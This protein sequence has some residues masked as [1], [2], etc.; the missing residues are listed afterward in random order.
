M[1]KEKKQFM[2]DLIEEIQLSIEENIKRE[3]PDII[4][5][6][7]S[8][9]WL[10]L[11]QR[12]NNPIDL[13]PMQKVMLK[14]FY[15][16]SLGNE[17][18]KLT[19]IE[20]ELL[21]ENN[22]D[23]DDRGNVLEK[24]YSGDLFRELVLVWGRRSGKDFSVAIIALYEA[25]KLLECEGGDPYAMYGLSS[26][27]PIN[28]LTVANAKG[29]ANIAFSEI[30]EK[31]LYS[32]Y[33][34]DKYIKEGIS[35]GSIYLL[36]PQDKIDNKKFKEQGL[37]QK[38]GSVGIL[39]GHSNSD[40]LLGM[41]CIVLILDEVAS[42]KTTGGSS[43]GDRIYAALTPTVQT[44]VRKV[45]QKDKNGEIELDQHG[46]KK[47][48]ER[49]YDGKIIS[50]SSPRAKEGKF[51]E[52]FNTA[53]NVKN[54]L[55]MRVPTWGI[56]IY[57]TRKSLRDDNNTMSEADF[58]MEFG[59]DFSGTGFE[60]FF[61]EEQIK[62]CFIGHNLKNVEMGSPGKIYFVHLDPA[63]SSHNYS[64]V[65]LHKEYYL[66]QQTQKADFRI[67]VDHIKFWQPINGS[68][69][70]NEV[71][72]YVLSLKRKFRIGLVTY[73][74]FASQESILKMRKAGIPNKETKFTATY[75]YNIYKELENLI[76]TGRLFI[77][78]GDDA[79]HLLYNEMIE[80]QRKFTPTGFKVLPKKEGDGAKSDDIVDSL[81]GACYVAIEKQMS[82]LPHSK[83][84]NL[85][86]PGGQQIAW[87]NMQGG[88]Y[89][90]GTGHQVANSLARRS[91]AYSNLN[92]FGRR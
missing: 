26:A 86:N 47:I 22:L 81:A 45:Y 27:A 82:K 59:A 8:E 72:Q 9:E 63:T 54:R 85:G 77:P 55:A 76:N 25:M 83:L 33:F 71:M 51:Y 28:I 73:D 10:G 60:S 38:K 16:G 68:I 65:D 12:E 2:G 80:L 46:Q 78:F 50:I 30:R 13:F 74:S 18:L 15:R 69:N 66:N 88:V 39:V 67:V 20:L 3:I 58:N 43:S 64:L 70:P 36:T 92:R 89:G 19:D 37:P 1:A 14:T 49:I 87:R 32:P 21:K 29:Q 7:E 41:G 35:A 5:F 48:K 52:L 56:N 91:R 61:T 11:K 90:V 6:V 42:Y 53:S 57:H 40:S 31:L 75:K 62:P 79:C 23:G 24:Y 17:N 4:T 34:K 84:A 44:Y